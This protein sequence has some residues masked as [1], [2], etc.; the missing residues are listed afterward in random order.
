MLHQYWNLQAI[1]YGWNAEGIKQA[2]W[3]TNMNKS[4]QKLR[5]VKSGS[6]AIAFTK[7]EKLWRQLPSKNYSCEQRGVTQHKAVSGRRKLKD[8]LEVDRHTLGRA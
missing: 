7:I 1:A 8:G 6:H 5:Q 2:N 3:K 4:K